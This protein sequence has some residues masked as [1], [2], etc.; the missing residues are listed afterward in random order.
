MKTVLIL[1][2]LGVAAMLA[3][4]VWKDRQSTAET[5]PAI[6]AFFSKNPLT[7]I[8]QM[9][10][11]RLVEALPDQLILAQVQVSQIVGIRN[12]PGSQAWF[13]K[14]SRKSV[15]FLVCLKDF[16]IVA[17][18]ELDDSTHERPERKKADADKDAALT[19]A[20]IH[21]VRIPAKALPTIQA[22]H[23]TFHS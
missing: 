7:E 15:D 10:Y 13:N 5:T 20:G 19:A 16:T 8:E 21:I 17:A 11:H 4:R 12:G 6:P 18:V 14:I 2:L 1:A 23:D 22:L 9:L 3:F